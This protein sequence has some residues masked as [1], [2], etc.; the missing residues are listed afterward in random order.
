[1]SK[2]SLDAATVQRYLQSLPEAE[3]AAILEAVVLKVRRSWEW[4][5]GVLIAVVWCIACIWIAS[6]SGPLSAIV[7]GFG[8][9]AIAAAAL[10]PFVGWMNNRVLRDEVAL[11]ITAN[12][13]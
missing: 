7:G 3:V 2:R 8:A 9:I 12:G 5:L 4:R 11:R 10:W 1:M 13:V 6:G